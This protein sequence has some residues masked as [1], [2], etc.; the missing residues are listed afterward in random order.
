MA[1]YDKMTFRWSNIKYNYAVEIEYF[2]RKSSHGVTSS[3]PSIHFMEHAMARPK[4]KSSIPG[5]DGIEPR[6]HAHSPVG[7]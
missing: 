3:P 1:I 5:V 2:N 4:G 6:R 7:Q